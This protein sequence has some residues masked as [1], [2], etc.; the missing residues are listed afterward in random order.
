MKS[1]KRL[2]IV[3]AAAAGI[4]LLP[5][6]HVCAKAP[7]SRAQNMPSFAGGK[8]AAE[9]PVPA[10]AKSAPPKVMPA[11]AGLV[12]L[13]GDTVKWRPSGAQLSQE[14]AVAT[15]TE[16][17]GMTCNDK[18]KSGATIADIVKNA[19]D[20]TAQKP[21][22]VILF[23]GAADQKAKTS[24]DD[25]AAAVTSVTKV[26]AAAG[27]RVYLVPSSINLD[28]AIVANL[29]I[30]ASGVGAVF[31][32]PGT[33]IG[34]HPYEEALADIARNE[35]EGVAREKAKTAAGMQ[36][37]AKTPAPT[38]TPAPSTQVTSASQLANEIAGTGS[39]TS[40]S[41]VQPG[42]GAP[43]TGRMIPPP[44]LKQFTPTD[45]RENIRKTE[46]GKKPAT[47]R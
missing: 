29:R 42:G 17:L 24:D 19:G 11:T 46:S 15:A 25:M 44:A 27:A 36:P 21:R 34:G 13:A 12:V 40:G 1:M 32:E 14:D 33:E 18:T 2:L 23:V 8:Q 16:L 7:K 5:S 41:V 31:I 10:P 39:T 20:I 35:K 30:A 6:A 43:Y 47:E 26:L 9:T 22:I 38:P 37:V 3:T 45:P 4:A 28:A